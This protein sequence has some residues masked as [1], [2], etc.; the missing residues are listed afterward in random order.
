M[1]TVRNKYGY[2]EKERVLKGRYGSTAKVYIFLGIGDICDM[3]N[4]KTLEECNFYAQVNSFTFP[5]NLSQI[6]G[7][8][9]QFA[10]V[11]TYR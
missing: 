6:L 2:T 9:V 10:K 11:S 7:N 8:L 5:R 3:F 1:S 4:G